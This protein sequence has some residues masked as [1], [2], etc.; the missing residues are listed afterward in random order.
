MHV[1]GT[2]GSCGCSCGLYVWLRTSWNPVDS[3]IAPAPHVKLI[4]PP[5]PWTR[6]RPH[7]AT[8]HAGQHSWLG[9][10]LSRP[11]SKTI[12]PALNSPHTDQFDLSTAMDWAFDR[13][14]H[15]LPLK[16]AEA[17]V[18]DI[19]ASPT[20]TVASSPVSSE[21]DRRF[22][23]HSLKSRARRSVSGRD[24]FGSG[25]RSSSQ[26]S[27]FRK[28]SKS[29]HQSTASISSLTHRDTGLSDESGHS[30]IAET[31]SAN[32]SF[33]NIDWQSQKV[34]GICSLEQD[35]HLLRTRIP[36][37]VVTSEYLIKLK[38]RND[39]YDLFPWLPEKPA[40]ET[41]GSTPEPLIVIPLSAVISVFPAESTRPSF[42][43]EVWWKGSCS[44]SFQQASFF[45]NLPGERDEQMHNIVRAMRASQHDDSE[46]LVPAPEVLKVFQTI[47]ES[48]EPSFRD[49][50]LEVFPVVPRANTRK[51]HIKKVEDSSK[52]PL[53][54]PSF[55]L[56]IGTYL[57]HFV[58]INKGKS[59]EPVHQH[60]T[61]GLLTLERIRGDWAIHEERF[62]L[63]F[64]HPFAPRVVLELS[65]RFYRRIIRV[66]GVADR[67]LKPTWPQMWQ[68][69]ELFRVSGLKEPQ[70][71]VP[72][73][74]F[75][76]VRRTLDA[77]LAAYRCRPVEWEIN[78]K[79]SFAPEFRLL[80]AKNGARYSSLQL[81]AVFRALRYNDY[82]NSLSFR[83]VD[84]TALS[85]AHDR[86]ATSKGHVAYL[87][88]T[89]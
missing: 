59:G 84:L 85:D 18:S 47:H 1:A 72:R 83:D 89:C 41:P 6:F 12:A 65:S 87:S 55:Y 22:S 51:T 81:L 8:Q 77:F 61:F 68:S 76:G 74:D 26:S 33:S 4:S 70:Y 10:P 31:P 64:R 40:Q 50:K 25:P 9:G 28:L 66:L 49:R 34:D 71:L 27:H 20:S 80:P 69:N 24:A 82:F 38:S 88:R 75:G 29:R 42:G 11:A 13:K 86:F 57:C 17:S 53:E 60:N 5:S 35:S 45:F 73:E 37:L 3:T 14:A 44:A 2:R 46:A 43:I 79:T 63:T 48:E 32:A 67:Y 39:V 62:N 21:G 58:V 78:W 7:S 23:L 15:L 52:K 56:V 16:T 54:S 30:S 19:V 36:Y